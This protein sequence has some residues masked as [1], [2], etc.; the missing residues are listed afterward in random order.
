MASPRWYPDRRVAA[1]GDTVMF[2]GKVNMRSDADEVER[3]DGRDQLL[4]DPVAER[5]HAMLNYPRM[6]VLPDGRHR[7][8]RPERQ[9]MFFDPERRGRGRQ[10]PACRRVS[11]PGQRRVD[12]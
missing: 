1:D 2:A 11:H 5:D 6:F 9:T 8:G 10:G 7:A 4:L 3:Y 12:A